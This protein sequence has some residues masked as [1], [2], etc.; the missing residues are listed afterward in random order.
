MA[1]RA[2]KP[3]AIQKRLKC[4]FYGAAGTGKT[5]CAISFPHVYLID[6]ERGAENTQYT[7]ILSKNGGVIFQTNDF[8][9]VFSEVIS[10]LTE[11]HEFKTLVI[12]S[13]TNLYNDL[14][15]KSAARNGTEF[16][17]HYADANKQ[18]KNLLNML[19]RL[20]M[21]V[22]VTCHSKTEYGT[23][24]AVLGQ[25]FDG[26]KKLDY[27]FDLVFEIQKRG[28]ERVGIAKKSRMESFPDGESFPFSYEEIAKR[29]GKD[30]LEKEAVPQEL[31]TEEQIKEI[32]R[33]IKVL[34][35]PSEVWLKWLDKSSSEKW[36]FMPRDTIQKCINFLLTKVPSEKPE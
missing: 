19:L 35:I 10:L 18:I 17:R 30:I 11:K 2:V 4:L 33:L 8:D 23:N 12:D 21:S 29:Y 7:D 34:K 5:T 6:T 31:A 36:E 16:G 25:V 26:Y 15:D 14:L 1:L 24:L 22:I 32:E 28:P 13:F 27:L 20:E 9:E 3:E